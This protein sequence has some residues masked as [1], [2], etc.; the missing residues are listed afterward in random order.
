VTLCNRQHSDA[1]RE[2]GFEI[3]NIAS[4][5]FAMHRVPTDYFDRPTITQNFAVRYR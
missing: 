3:S 5:A 1:A 2:L 4:V